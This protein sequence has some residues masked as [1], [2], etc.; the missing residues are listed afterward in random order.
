MDYSHHYSTKTFSSAPMRSQTRHNTLSLRHFIIVLILLHLSCS[1]HCL[2][3]GA[4]VRT[5][6]LLQLLVK[7]A[8]PEG[9]QGKVIFVM[10]EPLASGSIINSWG[11]TYKVP[12]SFRQA[13]FFFID[14]MPD[15]NWEHPCRYIFID[16]DT[17]NVHIL[18]A[19]TPPDRLINMIKLHPL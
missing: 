17:S 9:I 8:M 5:E 3:G 14:D 2:A 6:T 15:A 12:D 13:W 18:T 16:T 4:V 1:N 19:K 7:R 10:S 11:V